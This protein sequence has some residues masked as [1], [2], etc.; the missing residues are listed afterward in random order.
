MKNAPGAENPVVHRQDIPIQG[1]TV[2]M[3]GTTGVGWGTGVIQ[4]LPE[5]NILLL[6]A[7]L[8][9]KITEASA[10]ISDTFDG[11]IA[12]G[13]APTADAT[14]S[15][16]EVDIIPSTA[17][18]QAVSSVSTVRAPSTTTENG[19][20]LDN[21]AGSLELNLN[22]LIDDADISGDDNVTI[23]GVLHIVY[24]VLGDD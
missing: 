2:A 23:D 15:G 8:N 21:T 18:P 6:G 7:L 9:C 14:L 24:A 16:A 19:S 22:L 17:T 13:S 11:D 3:T 10:S 5:G 20:I 12:I 4:G 1:L